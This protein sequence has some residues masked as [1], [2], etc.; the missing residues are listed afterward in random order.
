M[1]AAAESEKDHS[2]ECQLAAEARAASLDAQVAKAAQTIATLRGQLADSL[3]R[4]Q[5][6]AAAAQLEQYSAQLQRARAKCDGAAAEAAQLRQEVV[7]TRAREETALAREGQV[8]EALEDTQARLTSAVA[9]TDQL[10]EEL[11]LSRARMEAVESELAACHS[12]ADSLD[13]ALAAV[14]AA[15]RC[16]LAQA[17]EQAAAARWDAQ[18]AR[19]GPGAGEMAARER[20]AMLVRSIAV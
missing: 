3:D 15:S 13:R 20:S 17:E 11:R 10:G 7:A 14:Q 6:S 5:H 1:Q 4:E 16:A 9:C 8:A 19:S 12:R 18:Q 2:K